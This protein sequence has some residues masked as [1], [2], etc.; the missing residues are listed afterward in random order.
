MYPIPAR[1]LA[2]INP[3]VS[4]MKGKKKFIINENY[5]YLINKKIY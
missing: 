1:Y 4:L 5:A 3:N 2:G